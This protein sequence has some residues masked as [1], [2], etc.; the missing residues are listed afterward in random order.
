MAAT[1]L[2]NVN[3]QTDFF[4]Q[5]LAGRFTHKLGLMAGI[6][7]EAPDALISP[8][9]SGQTVSV[10][11]WKAL[12][13]DSVQITAAGTTTINALEDFKNVAVWVER[14]KAWGA[15]DVVRYIGNKDAGLAVADMVAGYWAAELQKVSLA[16]LTGAFTTA[17]ASTH[18]L[19]DS[20]ATITAEK[21]IDAKL[22][23]G[24]NAENLAYAIMNSKVFGDLLK[25]KIV[26]YDQAQADSVVSGGVPQF[27]GLNVIT[28]DTLTAVSSVYKTYL[29]A[30]G[31]LVYKFRN[32]TKSAYSDANVFNVGGI[33]IEL[34]RAA[35]TGGGT[36]NF[37][38]RASFFVHLSGMAYAGASNPTN[39]TLATGASWS[40]AAN[41]DKLISVVQYLSL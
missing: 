38:T 26:N 10:P 41:D 27:L 15:E 32:R 37:I 14:E 5:T 11:Q 7:T 39:T 22:K 34:D 28:D 9:E 6:L 4:K 13:G 2:S 31:S 18:V 24:D 29:A 23:L 36:D 25:L 8:N 12:S 16:V 40:K 19:D 1:A 30:P 33:E 17:L 20:S 35:T 3:F 21:I